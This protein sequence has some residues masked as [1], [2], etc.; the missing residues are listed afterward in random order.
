MSKFNKAIL[1]IGLAVCLTG[2]VG[3]PP[4]EASFRY[5]TSVRQQEHDADILMRKGEDGHGI[6]VSESESARRLKPQILS[7]QKRV[8]DYNHL[9]MTDKPF[10]SQKDYK[11]KVHPVVLTDNPTGGLSIGAGRIYLGM[12]YIYGSGMQ[13]G[14]I[15]NHYDAAVME[16]VL[17]HEITHATNGT[18]LRRLGLFIIFR[19]GHEARKEELNAEIGSAKL[20]EQLP[21]GGWG[22]FLLGVY[23]NG[24]ANSRYEHASN[25][26]VKNFER[27]SKGRVKFNHFSPDAYGNEASIQYISADSTEYPIIGGTSPYEHTQ[28]SDATY[29]LGG[30]IAE[31]IAKGAFQPENL[32]IM[33][34]YELPDCKFDS[35]CV[36]VCKS[37][38]LPNGY[39][40]LACLYKDKSQNFMRYLK[41]LQGIISA[42]PEYMQD[43]H[44]K[45]WTKDLESG[46]VQSNT[47]SV[48]LLAEVI[49]LA[50]DN[51]ARK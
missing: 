46:P 47:K 41:E 42:H 14:R 45:T 9:E 37:D 19:Q 26:V 4:A 44:Y 23:R 1:A 48:E 11:T 7:L 12:D 40:V 10:T 22:T 8:M 51:A 20:L 6:I 5:E 49:A 24:P 29:Y 33:R 18:S 21:E 50:R 43:G 17:A 3:Q 28:K 16:Q 13:D 2:T 39:R 35:D 30:Q 38:K 27:D 32:A 25:R 15:V 34:R 31:C 36:L